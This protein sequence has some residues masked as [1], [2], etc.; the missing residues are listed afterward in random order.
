[1]CACMSQIES[2]QLPQSLRIKGMDGDEIMSKAI[3][4]VYIHDLDGGTPPPPLPPP[5]LQAL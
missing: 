2:V 5:H 3:T 1:M 4:N